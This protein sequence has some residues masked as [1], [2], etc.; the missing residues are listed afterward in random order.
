M[1]KK[2]Y[3]IIQSSVLVLGLVLG[4]PLS[5]AGGPILRVP[6]DVL[7]VVVGGFLS[8]QDLASFGTT[9]KEYKAV[10]REAFERRH[11]DLVAQ[12]R[13][14]YEERGTEVPSLVALPSKR[15]AYQIKDPKKAERDARERATEIQGTAKSLCEAFGQKLERFEVE[16]KSDGQFLVLEGSLL[17]QANEV[18]ARL[19]R[20]HVYKRDAFKAAGREALIS[21]GLSVTPGFILGLPKLLIIEPYHLVRD[22]VRGLIGELDYQTGLRKYERG[23]DISRAKMG[24]FSSYN[25]T[26]IKNREGDLVPHEVFKSLVCVEKKELPLSAAVPQVSTVYTKKAAY[27][28]LP[29]ANAQDEGGDEPSAASAQ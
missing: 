23:P 20:P 19:Y 13:K 6:K 1:V 26:R 24:R 12:I 9:S 28:P 29:P 27:E 4:E 2:S 10:A 7:K 14:E 25:S 15:S 8:S 3:F 21:L 17:S 16:G 22:K 18:D 11:V 5:Q